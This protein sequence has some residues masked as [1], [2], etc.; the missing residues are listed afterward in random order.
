MLMHARLSLLI[1]AI[2]LSGCASMASNSSCFS[3]RPSL[4]LP[5][6]QLAL[7]HLSGGDTARALA[8]AVWDGEIDRAAQM[9]R[10]DPR[11]L[12]VQVQFDPRM[13]SPPPGQ[14]G[15]LLA[16]AVAQCDRE[17]V[18]MLLASGIP[19]NGVQ[20]GEALILALLANSPEMADLL[21]AAGASPDPQKVGGKNLVYELSAMGGV[22]GI[23]TL[24]RHGLDL[25]WVD[26]QGNDHLDTAL[27]M[28]QYV[29]AEHLVRAGAKLWRINGAGAVSAWT[30]AKE[31]V[32]SPDRENIAARSRLLV[33]AQVE[34]LPW[35]PP[36]PSKIRN[37]V[38]AKLWP[39]DA[40]SKAGMLLSAEAEADINARF[41][42]EAR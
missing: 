8:E 6:R 28:E 27:T 12:N 31:P 15:D 9:L 39:T 2:A 1:A 14:Y 37:M 10:N 16:F 40:L 34:G 7:A 18:H 36:D 13:Q 19:A 30:L 32:L 41:G 21:L 23:Q 3:H 11:L 4:V 17:M 24:I 22:G 33:L 38:L 29:I 20:K 42:D 35:P 5:D 25:A 26:R